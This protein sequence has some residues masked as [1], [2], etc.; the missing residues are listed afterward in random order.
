MFIKFFLAVVTLLIIWCTSGF[1]CFV[2]LPG[3][4]ELP[5]WSGIAAGLF[6]FALQFLIGYGLIEKLT[7]K[8]VAETYI[9]MLEKAGCK[10][11]SANISAPILHLA[12]FAGIPAWLRR[13]EAFTQAYGHMRFAQGPLWYLGKA[14]SVV[15]YCLEAP[16]FIVSVPGSGE[17]IIKAEQ[18][19]LASD[20]KCRSLW[21]LTPF[22]IFRA[23]RYAAGIKLGISGSQLRE[24]VTDKRRYL[25]FGTLL[26]GIVMAVFGFWWAP[27][28][29]LGLGLMARELWMYGWKQVVSLDEAVNMALQGKIVRISIPGTLYGRCLQANAV[30][31]KLPDKGADNSL[32]EAAGDKASSDS[33]NKRLGVSIILDNYS[34]AEKCQVEVIG[35]LMPD[36]LHLREYKVRKDGKT[37]YRHHFFWHLCL[38]AFMIILGAAWYLLQNLGI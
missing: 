11:L 30:Q 6:C 36:T 17:T 23:E 24:A 14:C 2:F 29:F 1:F 21:P 38:F 13:F 27:V 19:I 16:L 34:N 10:D 3:L 9:F 25:P 33:G 8:P 37:L 31:G 20:Y 7:E 22:S 28:M 5:Y 18:A 12:A 4:S 32:G 15:A 26:I 35:C